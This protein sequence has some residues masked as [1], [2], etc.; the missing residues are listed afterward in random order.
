VTTPVARA[1]RCAK[2]EPGAAS[3]RHGQAGVPAEGLDV[4]NLS[5]DEQAAANTVH[6]ILAADPSLGPVE[7][8]YVAP[9]EEVRDTR[10]LILLF[11]GE[12]AFMF[13]RV[14]GRTTIVDLDD[15]GLAGEARLAAKLDSAKAAATKAKLSKVYVVKRE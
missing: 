8:V 4:S 6:A 5:D 2:R 14:A 7:V 15:R 12:R 3:K 11:G 10:Y 1:I 13:D 9:N